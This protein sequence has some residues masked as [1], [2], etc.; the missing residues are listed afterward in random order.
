MALKLLQSGKLLAK[1]F[2]NL[3]ISQPASGLL[4]I[5]PT[6]PVITRNFPGFFTKC[7]LK[8]IFRSGSVM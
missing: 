4:K 1:A 5:N 7:E 2:Q 8:F 3:H 6:F